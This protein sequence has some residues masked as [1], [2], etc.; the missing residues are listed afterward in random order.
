M[1]QGQS[2][3]NKDNFQFM[4]AWYLFEYTMCALQN[5]KF[6]GTGDLKKKKSH[7]TSINASKSVFGKYVNDQMEHTSENW[8]QTFCYI[9]YLPKLIKASSKEV[10]GRLVKN[11]QSKIHEVQEI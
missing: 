4:N 5:N 1:W 2:K 7:N 6:I 10:G 3:E 11:N 8:A 9:D